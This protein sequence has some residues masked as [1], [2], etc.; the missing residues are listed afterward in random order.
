MSTVTGPSAFGDR[1]LGAL[2]LRTEAYEAVEGDEDATWQAAL[3]VVLGALA[4]GIGA[5]EG[6]PRGLLV[7]IALAL[8]GWAAYAYITYLIGTRLLPESAT[9]ADWGELLR[10]LGFASAPR[11]FLVLGIV[12]IVNIIVG[13]VVA[14]WV[15]VATVVA[16]RC[17]LD[18]ESWLR[19]IAVAFLGWLTLVVV[20]LVAAV[21]AAAIF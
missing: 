16:I 19:A 6:G 5:L 15:L 21:I 17:A 10:V 7:G 2:M 9:R 20:Q 18:Y 13:I 3:V 8:V 12:P 1:V 14:L 11:F 4:S